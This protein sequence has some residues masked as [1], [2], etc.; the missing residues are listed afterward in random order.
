MNVFMDH[1]IIYG[2][3]CCRESNKVLYTLNLRSLSKDQQ[4]ESSRASPPLTLPNPVWQ[5]LPAWHQTSRLPPGPIVP[6]P[7]PQVPPTPC[8][9]SPLG[10]IYPHTPDLDQDIHPAHQL[11]PLAPPDVIQPKPFPASRPKA[12]PHILSSVPSCSVHIR[13]RNNTRHPCA[14]FSLQRY[15][16]IKDQVRVSSP[17]PTRPVATF[18]MRVT[19]VRPGQ[20]L[21]GG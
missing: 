17:K 7:D 16:H 8:P 14:H 21:L 13:H 18:A 4:G 2:R 12:P 9:T 3:S 15:K 19:S 20:R 6:A 1:I 11:S 10:Q 5:P